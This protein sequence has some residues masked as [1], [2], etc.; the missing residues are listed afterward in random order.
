MV[1]QRMSNELYLP[2]VVIFEL[3]FIMNV[4]VDGFGFIFCKYRTKNAEEALLRTFKEARRNAPCVL[5]LPHIDR[6]WNTA[7]ESLQSCLSLLINDIPHDCSILL[8][9]TSDTSF[10]NLDNEIKNIFSIY[11]CSRLNLSSDQNKIVFSM[12]MNFWKQ[13]INFATEIPQSKPKNINQYP[14][15]PIDSLLRMLL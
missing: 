13:L 3:N 6:W 1:M 14:A 7:H 12:R 8:L 10:N 4:I 11:S 15:L 9:S 5:Y 2:K